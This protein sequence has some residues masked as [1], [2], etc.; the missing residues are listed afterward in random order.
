MTPIKEGCEEKAKEVEAELKKKW[1]QLIRTAEEIY[2]LSV[3][4][5]K[6]HYNGYS[7]DNI[8]FGSYSL[9]R[10]Y[11]NKIADSYNIKRIS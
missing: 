11:L 7:A 2:H 1:E 6:Y 8:K 10:E 5:D 3:K 9:E 4:Y